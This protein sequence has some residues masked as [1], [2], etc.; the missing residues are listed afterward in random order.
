MKILVRLTL[1]VFILYAMPVYSE[2]GYWQKN[3]SE[4]F[5]NYPVNDLWLG[6]LISV[7]E[8]QDYTKSTIQDEF[9]KTNSER[10]IWFLGL[11]EKDDEIRSF[12]NPVDMWES[13]QGVRGYV[14]IRK[15]KQ[16]ATYITDTS[17]IEQ[18]MFVY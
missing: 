6:A 14:L 17:N 16:V 8:F 5:F 15:G 18:F 10:Q 2:D 1:T 4:E 9:S 7:T 3:Y 12:S 13:L 11:Y